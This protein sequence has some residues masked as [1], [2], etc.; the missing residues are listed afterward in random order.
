MFLI[1]CRKTCVCVCVCFLYY[2]H[3]CSFRLLIQL[4]ES[5]NQEVGGEIMLYIQ[6]DQTKGNIALLQ[7]PPAFI[8]PSMP[9]S[10]EL[11]YSYLFFYLPTNLKRNSCKV[12][13]GIPPLF[14]CL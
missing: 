2:A 4:T 5:V 9:V 13:M 11:I 6:S 10:I 1:S 3:R 8:P 12:I 7:L 14:Y